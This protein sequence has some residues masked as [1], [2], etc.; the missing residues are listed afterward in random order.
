MAGGPGTPR[1]GMNRDIHSDTDSRGQSTID[2]PVGGPFV[3]THFAYNP[4]QESREMG[5]TPGGEPGQMWDR[6]KMQ[7]DYMCN[8]DG[9][10][11]GNRTLSNLDE[12][13]VL[14]NTIYSVDCEYDEDSPNGYS[15]AQTHGKFD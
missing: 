9:Y 4:V 10:V 8:H 7:A 2:L 12:R 11:S 13:K 14:Q 6:A 1:F 3:E 15:P 5:T